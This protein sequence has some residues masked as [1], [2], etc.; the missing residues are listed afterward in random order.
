VARLA[1]ESTGRPL[2]NTG[3]QPTLRHRIET[4]MAQ[5]ASTY[6]ATAHHIIDTDGLTIEEIAKR[7]VHILK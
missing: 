1:K 4:L 5:R 6:E 3:N 7:L 2:L